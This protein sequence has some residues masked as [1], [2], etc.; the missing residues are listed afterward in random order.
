[1]IHMS[2]RGRRPAYRDERSAGLAVQDRLDEGLVPLVLTNAHV[3]DPV[4]HQAAPC[5]HRTDRHEAR[6]LWWAGDT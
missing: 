2:H 1:M 5:R 3:V 6:Q 4:Q